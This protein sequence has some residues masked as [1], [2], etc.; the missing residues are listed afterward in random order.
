MEQIFTEAEQ[1]ALDEVVEKLSNVDKSDGDLFDIAATLVSD[2]AD[3]IKAFDE[4]DPD[5]VEAEKRDAI[6]TAIALISKL[7]NF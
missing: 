5:K 4:E 6:N 7:N 1:K 3:I 2:I